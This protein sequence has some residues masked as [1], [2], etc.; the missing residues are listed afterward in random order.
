MLQ[1]PLRFSHDVLK[2]SI[3]PGDHVI[4]ATV[5]NGNDTVMLAKA[6]EQIGKVYGFDVQKE[7]IVS[8]KDKLILTGLLP[9]TELIHDGHENIKDYVPEK[10]QIS[11]AIFNL[12]YLPSG[13]KSI[14]TKPETTL[15]AINQCLNRLRKGGLI[16]IMIYSG[17]EG[18]LKE[19]E[20]VD[21]FVH[22]LPQEDFQ[23]LEYK[24]VNQKNNPPFLYL[25]EKR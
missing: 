19:K 3:V 16:S 15:S 5:G 21:D 23:V 1:A 25:I 20:A 9:Q 22:N 11:A 24:F 13:D 8:T 7:A 10:E 18:G 14:I 17:H 2:K 6:V 12:G 4:D